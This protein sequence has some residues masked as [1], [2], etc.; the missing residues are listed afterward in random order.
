MGGRS[1]TVVA[2]W[3]GSVEATLGAAQDQLL[4][5]AEI[6]DVLPDRQSLIDAGNDPL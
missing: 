5:S 2:D 3:E 4:A 1:W 6:L